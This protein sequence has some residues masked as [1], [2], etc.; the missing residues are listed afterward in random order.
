MQMA[1]IVGRYITLPQWVFYVLTIAVI[2]GLPI[3]VFLAWKFE[4][5][6]T[7]F[8]STKSKA[9]YENPYTS[10]QKKPFSGNI[11]LG[12]LLALIILIS[13]GSN[14]LAPTE[15]RDGEVSIAIIPFRNYTNK[16]ELDNF[17]FGLA[18]EIRTQLSLTKKFKN[19]S[20]EQSTIRF[21][22]SDEDPV[23]IGE[24]LK[25]DYLILGNFQQAGEKIKVS[26]EMVDAVSGKTEIQFPPFL[27]SFENYTE[28]FNIQTEIAANVMDEFDFESQSLSETP[29]TS[30]KAFTN[31]GLA[32]KYNDKGWYSE[33]DQIMAIEY[34]QKAVA[35]DSSYLSAWVLL[36][37]TKLKYLWTIKQNYY[38]GT[39]PEIDI[40]SIEK[41]L[42]YIDTNFQNSWEVDYIKG[43]YNYTGLLDYNSG[44]EFLLKALAVNPEDE[45][46]NSTVSAIYKRKLEFEKALPYRL[47][48]IE[49][50]PLYA[51]NWFELSYIFSFNGDL[52]NQEKAILK[53]WEMD[54]DTEEALNRTYLFYMRRRGLAN[55][56][57]AIMKNEEY[58]S[59]ILIDKYILDRKWQELLDNIDSL[60]GDYPDYIISVKLEA[61]WQL[62]NDD[63]IKH[64]LAKMKDNDLLSMVL[65]ENDDLIQERLKVR[66]DMIDGGD[67]SELVFQKFTNLRVL[68][69]SGKYVEATAALIEMNNS[70]PNWGAYSFLNHTDF[71][72][73]K[74]NYTPFTEAINNLKL[75]SKLGEKNP[76]DL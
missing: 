3:A 61:Y 49:I 46:I 41:D 25:V 23:Q 29:T 32:K 26:I 62:G 71:Y 17:G 14:M 43:M 73:I 54:G 2:S 35:L 4:K 59:R 8:I 44:L 72:K 16:T 42:D 51:Q 18:D 6:P 52:I 13:V 21:H 11:Y 31:Y 38:E 67:V 30:I 74:S 50:N 69:L 1:D 27:T 58:S 37:D 48:T 39:H 28:L 75:P 5:G 64:Y 56:P 76:L 34:A 36:A 63:S 68:A 33:E 66:Q 22:E 53:A 24:A 40:A 45:Q 10:A 19:I 57:E 47:K 15:V 20:S 9:A 55:L 60:E 12:S 7:G 70:H 65:N